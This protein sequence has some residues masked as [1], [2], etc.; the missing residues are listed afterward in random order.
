MNIRVFSNF[1]GIERYEGVWAMDERNAGELRRMR[2]A[3]HVHMHFLP[4]PERFAIVQKRPQWRMAPAPVMSFY[5][6]AGPHTRPEAQREP[7]LFAQG[8]ATLVL[9]TT[10]CDFTPTNGVPDWD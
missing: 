3:G 5:Y 1:N 9:L 4:P 8:A 6:A 7:A 2:E 10:R